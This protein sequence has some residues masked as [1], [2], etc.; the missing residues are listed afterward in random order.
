MSEDVSK[1]P[2][3]VTI[4]ALWYLVLAGGAAI[5][6]CAITIPIGV[7]S[8]VDDLPA[9]GSLIATLALGFGL[10]ITT[11]VG[12]ICAL[13]AWGLWNMKRWARITALVLAILHL[14]FFPVGTAIGVATL[15]YAGTHPEVERAFANR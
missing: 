1:R 8:L 2:D 4:L 6:A 15:W 5:G 12:A 3:G 13:V 10:T 7:I 9:G 14:P 11:V